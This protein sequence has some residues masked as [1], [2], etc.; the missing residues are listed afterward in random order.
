MFNE[1]YFT[2]IDA[3]VSG[4]MTPDERTAFE[5]RLKTEPDLATELA[6]FQQVLGNIEPIERQQLRHQIGN[7][8]ADLKTD[9]FFEKGE[10]SAV[11]KSSE[12]KTGPLSM[13]AKIADIHAELGEKGFFEPQNDVKTRRF[14]I[15]QYAAAASVALLV[16][17]G[18]WLYS[19]KKTD[20]T[21]TIVAA[22]FQSETAVPEVIIS[23]LKS[24]TGMAS[25]EA[26]DAD[27]LRC[28]ELYKAK[29]YAAARPALQQHIAQFGNQSDVKAA[30]FYYALACIGDNKD[31]EKAI[32]ILENLRTQTAWASDANWF[33]ALAYLENGRYT[34]GSSMLKKIAESND[35][36]KKESI[37]LLQKLDKK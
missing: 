5:N 15:W 24:Q 7:V 11:E 26:S 37:E 23:K 16:A 21:G 4:N 12:E 30:Q 2:E 29:N 18:F 33:L 31:L 8:A 19:P 3:Y 28:L 35:S 22:A 9:G 25:G 34:E 6:D 20:N 10:N 27:L 32:P 36:F 13:R 17:V 14:S 1:I